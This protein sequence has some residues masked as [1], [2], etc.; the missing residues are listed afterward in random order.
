MHAMIKKTNDAEELI[1]LNRFNLFHLFSKPRRKEAI[2]S[3]LI[4][5]I[6]KAS[7]LLFKGMLPK[8][9]T[10]ITPNIYRIVADSTYK[11]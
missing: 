1:V 9:V 2:C 8:N 4:D 7:R 5:S 3:M 10:A 6:C 11:K